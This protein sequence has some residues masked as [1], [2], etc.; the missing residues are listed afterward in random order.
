MAKAEKNIMVPDV[1]PLPGQMPLASVPDVAPVLAALSKEEKK[2]LGDDLLSAL[3]LK[4]SAEAALQ[5]ARAKV[6]AV[7]A[8]IVKAFG[9]KGPFTIPT[10]TGPRQFTASKA[11]AEEGG[12]TMREVSGSKETLG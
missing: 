8:A 3:A 11:K 1:A 9:H 12:F 2:K 10:P 4:D 7:G 6:G 5:D